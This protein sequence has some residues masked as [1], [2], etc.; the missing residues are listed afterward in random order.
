MRAVVATVATVVL[1]CAGLLVWRLAPR[2]LTVTSGH[3]PEELVYV[4][5]SDDVLKVA[6]M[7][8]GAAH[9]A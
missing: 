9:L 4:R 7:F 2:R 5:S 8:K 6:A 1:L 3:F